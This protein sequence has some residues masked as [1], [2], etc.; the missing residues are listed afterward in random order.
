MSRDRSAGNDRPTPTGLVAGALVAVGVLLFMFVHEGFIALSGLGAFGPGV[1]REFGLL[2]DQ[3]EFQRQAAQKAGY[4]AYLVGGLF[5]CLAFA[6]LSGSDA[7]EISTDWVLMPLLV[8][9]ITWMFSGPGRYWGARKMVARM[10]MT[11]GAFWTVFVGAEVVGSIGSPEPFQIEGLLVGLLS[12]VPFFALAWAAGR[13]PRLT[14]MLLLAIA[15]VFLLAFG[16]TW[17]SGRLSVASVLSTVALILV[18]IVG[19]AVALIRE[20]PAAD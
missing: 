12:V 15:G 13:W 10:L 9:W 4:H 6:W 7:T 8:L 17:A 18:P 14:G 20:E 19:S 11:F 1:L 2:K 16:P 5:I 3:D